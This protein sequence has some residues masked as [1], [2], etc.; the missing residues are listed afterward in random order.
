MVD[1]VFDVI[2][3]GVFDEVLVGADLHDAH[4]VADF[5]G[6]DGGAFKGE[7]RFAL[8][9]GVEGEDACAVEG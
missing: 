9:E 3:V 1:V 2:G 4:V 7:D 5:G 6:G 8:G